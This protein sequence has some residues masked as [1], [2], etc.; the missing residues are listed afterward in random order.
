MSDINPATWIHRIVGWCFGLL[1]GAIA[2]SCALKVLECIWPAL[3][4]IVGIIGIIAVFVRI[5]V[6]FTSRNSW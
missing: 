2:L 4:V 5:V 6:Y 1:A 3:V